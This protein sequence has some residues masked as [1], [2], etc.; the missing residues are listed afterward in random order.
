MSVAP[1]NDPVDLTAVHLLNHDTLDL[2]H[3]REPF[4]QAGDLIKAAK[5]FFRRKSRVNCA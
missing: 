4:I 5:T 1:H 2:L 3:H